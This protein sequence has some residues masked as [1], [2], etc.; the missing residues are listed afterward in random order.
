MA[1]DSASMALSWPNTTVFR[2]RSSVASLLRSSL[3]TDCGGMRAIFETMF[4]MST[5]PITFF[6]R[7]RQALRGGLVDRVDGLVRQVAVVDEA[8]RQFRGGRQRA[9]AE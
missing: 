6:A 8:R 9:A 4:S 1:A 5:L 3:E 7:T 2:S